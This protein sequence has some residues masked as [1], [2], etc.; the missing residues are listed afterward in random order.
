MGGATA[1]Y[2]PLATASS[3]EELP[4]PKSWYVWGLTVQGV[5]AMTRRK[6]MRR[7]NR[8]IN[9]RARSTQHRNGALRQ[10]IDCIQFRVL[11][12]VWFHGRLASLSAE[13]KLSYHV[14]GGRP[15]PRKLFR[16]PLIIDPVQC[17]PHPASTAS[18][19]MVCRWR[20]PTQGALPG[21]RRLRGARVHRVR[22]LPVA[23][24][25]RRGF[26]TQ[27]GEGSIIL[28]NMNSQDQG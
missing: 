16:L 27:G 3:K 6:C 15:E 13:W 2:R 1:R 7:R 21:Q 23:A 28:A 8:P 4:H 17:S 9:W 14:Q 18:T 24:G 20:H 25:R 11:N 19:T 26:P 10:L 22:A 5:M 12:P